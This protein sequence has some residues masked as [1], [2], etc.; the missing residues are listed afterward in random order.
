MP[1]LPELYWLQKVGASPRP[2]R[3]RTGVASSTIM[4]VYRTRMVAHHRGQ[5]GSTHR[6]SQSSIG[7]IRL[8]R[9]HTHRARPQPQLRGQPQA[10]LQ[11][12][13][14]RHPTALATQ[15]HRRR[16]SASRL[17]PSAHA[18]PLT[19]RAAIALTIP[20]ILN[21]LTLTRGFRSK[22]IIFSIT[23][24]HRRL[25]R[26]RLS[27]PCLP[28]STPLTI[29]R[30]HLRHRIRRLEGTRIPM[31]TMGT[32]PTLSMATT[33]MEVTIRLV[34]VAVAAQSPTYAHTPQV[35][36]HLSHGTQRQRGCA[37]SVAR[38]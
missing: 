30:R 11:A 19:R 21:G 16:L 24:H 8:R 27:Q 28:Q 1:D 9:P 31:A 15:L 5:T 6:Q 12:R 36:C 13:T 18:R 17:P 25:I 35:L 3:G 37:S 29:L 2:M 32:V 33:A 38:A 4:V 23:F 22:S 34:E 26:R 20:S 10:Q 7:P 14:I